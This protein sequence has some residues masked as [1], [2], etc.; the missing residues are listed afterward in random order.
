MCAEKTKLVAGIILAGGKSRRMD[1]VDKTNILFYNKQ[2][3]QHVFFRAKDQVAVL[4]INSNNKKFSSNENIP[5]LKDSIPGFLGPL[6]GVYTGL[7]WVKKEL[8][9]INWLMTFPVDSP[10][11]P[12]NLVNLLSKNINN[13]KIIMVKSGERIHPTFTLWHVDLLD[14]LELA[15][16]E[17]KLKID[18]FSKNFQ[19]KVVNFPIIDYDPFYNINNLKNL[20]EARKIYKNYFKGEQ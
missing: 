1:G 20:K 14:S 5:V 3:W 18:K 10:F 9:K 15:L 8:G 19:T 11:F 17:K 16:K 12:K 7:N 2:L 4:A 6:A 13:E